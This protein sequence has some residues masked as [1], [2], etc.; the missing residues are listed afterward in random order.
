M[1]TY[2]SISSLLIILTIIYSCSNAQVKKENTSLSPIEFSEKIKEINSPII[3]DVR[4]PEE[5]TNGHLQ[6][7]KNID[8]NGDDF[9]KQ[10]SLLAAGKI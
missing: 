8:W 3:L 4:T 9:E 1:R 2:I 7:A 10:I 6:N 5:Y